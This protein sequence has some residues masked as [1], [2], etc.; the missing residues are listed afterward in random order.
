MAGAK[1]PLVT[2][3]GSYTTPYLIGQGLKAETMISGSQGAADR[4]I[5]TSSGLNS[6]EN[7]NRFFKAAM[8][9]MVIALIGDLTCGGQTRF[10]W[11]LKAV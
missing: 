1:H 3:D 11:Q 2:A 10:G 6:Q 7:L 8:Q 5:G 4:G 9:E